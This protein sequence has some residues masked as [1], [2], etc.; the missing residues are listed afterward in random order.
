MPPEVL[1][2]QPAEKDRIAQTNP[3]QGGD[4]QPEAGKRLLSLL[5]ARKIV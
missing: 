5:P 2:T 4:K 3:E 1:V